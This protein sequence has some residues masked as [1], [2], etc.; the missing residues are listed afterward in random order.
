M[1][2]AGDVYGKMSYMIEKDMRGEQINKDD[3]VKRERT[4]NEERKR[5]R[6]ETPERASSSD[7]LVESDQSEDVIKHEKTEDGERKRRREETPERVRR[8]RASRSD[9]SV[10]SDRAASMVP[11]WTEVAVKTDRDGTASCPSSTPRYSRKYEDMVKEAEERKEARKSTDPESVVSTVNPDPIYRRVLSVSMD[12][13]AEAFKEVKDFK[14]GRC[15]PG[16]INRDS[17]VV[18]E[19]DRDTP[20]EEEKILPGM[21]TEEGKKRW[22]LRYRHE[23]VYELNCDL[24]A[25][26][27]AELKKIRRMRNERNERGDCTRDNANMEAIGQRVAPNLDRSRDPRNCDGGRRESF[28]RTPANANMEAVGQRE[29]PNHHGRSR[30]PERGRQ[31]FERRDESDRNRGDFRS[32]DSRS[33]RTEDSRRDRGHAMSP[34]THSRERSFDR[35]R[36]S[37]SRHSDSSDRSASNSRSESSRDYDHYKDKRGRDS[38]SKDMNERGE[39]RF[40]SSRYESDRRGSSDRSFSKLDHREESRRDNYSRHR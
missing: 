14:K 32:R 18:C 23:C 34:P 21:E 38:P 33:E 22:R 12:D 8:H 6:E 39:H 35:N 5:R 11:H 2:L 19:R 31:S 15:A 26:S 28:D 25:Q 7:G 3:M 10:D 16:L 4:D 9:S 17:L 37:L 30:E 24:L 20:L 13:L 1:S 27:I 40:S 29:P 36:R